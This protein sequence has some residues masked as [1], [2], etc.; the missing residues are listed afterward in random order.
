MRVGE[1]QDDSQIS[2]V[3]LEASDQ[4]ACLDVKH[5]DNPV[6]PSQRAQ[7]AA[8]MH[9]HVRRRCTG[10]YLGEQ[11]EALHATQRE[12]CLIYGTV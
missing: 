1:R 3:P 4:P 6:V 8:A 12:A 9:A 11:L 10:G 7:S 5:A 2:L